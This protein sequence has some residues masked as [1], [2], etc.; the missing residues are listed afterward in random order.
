MATT[1]QR[2]EKHLIDQEGERLLR[3]KLPSHWVLRE[4]RP[5]YGLDFALEIFKSAQARQAMYETLGEHLFVQLKTIEKPVVSPLTIFARGNVEKGPEYLDHADKIADVDT[6]RFQLETSELMTVE[7][8]GIG[9]PVLLVI[10]DLRAQRCSFVCINDYIDKILVPRHSDYRAK[11]FQPRLASVTTSLYTGRL[12]RT[13]SRKWGSCLSAVV[14]ICSG[15]ERSE[16]ASGRAIS[17]D[18]AGV[19]CVVWRGN[20]LYCLSGAFALESRISLP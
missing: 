12:S 10:A 16:S 2:S 14:S 6:Y 15:G 13:F 5:D 19:P 20:V 7:R 11:A 17:W 4:Y 9:L 18:M 8:M 1:K 3:S